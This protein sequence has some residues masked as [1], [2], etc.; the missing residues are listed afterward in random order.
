MQNQIPPVSICVLTYGNYP[1]LARRC[2]E[3]IRCNC[4]LSFYQ[5]I[6][7]ANE[8]CPET[9]DY[10]QILAAAGEIDHLELSPVNIHK[11]PMM[12]RMFAAISTEYIWWF[13]DD[14][15]IAAPDAFERQ[16][17]AVRTSPAT[18][19]LWGDGAYCNQPHD[20]IKLPDI[21][22]FI[23]S[24][25]WYRGLTPPAW[26]P[27]GKGELN[28]NGQGTGDGRWLFVLG[29]CWWARTHC[30]RTLDWPDRR[31][32]QLGDDVLLA[33]AMRQQGW[34]VANI[35]SPGVVINTGPRRGTGRD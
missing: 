33:E 3:S 31:L 18:V 9:H 21:K 4:D 5:L 35:G 25:F 13:D 2:I 1:A 10:L 12:R 7:G 22:S 20:F 28:F 29:G 14:S 8:V 27:G 19:V 16:F 26:E 34:H 6:V 17:E 11:C 30:L 24:A 15:Y 32:A 23:R